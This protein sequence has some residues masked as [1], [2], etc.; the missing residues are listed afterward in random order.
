[1]AKTTKSIV[2]ATD[3][4]AAALANL[5]DAQAGQVVAEHASMNNLAVFGAMLAGTNAALGQIM[6][7]AASQ[8]DG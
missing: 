7:T 2:K 5:A 1:M 3:A 8:I 6:Q 4:Q